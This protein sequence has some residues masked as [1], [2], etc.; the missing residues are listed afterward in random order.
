MRVIFFKK[1]YYFF[2]FLLI[3]IISIF[4]LE[5]LLRIYG[6]GDPIVYKTNLSYR[7]AP[8]ANQSVVRLKKSKISINESGLRSTNEWS[9][10]NN[11][12]VLFFGDSVTYGGS[13]IDD[14]EIFSELVCYNLNLA[15]KKYLCGNAGVNAYGVDNIN[16]RILYGEVQD[17]K[18][19]VVTLIEGDGYRSLQDVMAI[20]AFLDKPR[21]L[22]AIQEV[23]LHLTWKFNIFLRSDYSYNYTQQN[24][25]ETNSID[26]FQQSFKRLK[27]TLIN[28]LAKNKKILVVFHPSKESVLN[29]IETVEY[30]LMKNIFE[31][32]KS[33]I[34]FLDMFPIIK[35][36]YSS[37][38][39]YDTVHLDKKGHLLF[40]EQISKIINQYDNKY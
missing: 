2:I 6:L 20:P 29:G 26:I 5:T 28:E 3:F 15:K 30:K 24:K 21:L 16:N 8:K 39:Y 25:E 32:D 40:A 33:K 4:F 9:Q 7:Y 13:Y 11:H 31:E 37:N 38:I 22:P 17:S 10:N 18:W 12:K 35:S 23:L 36:F 1:A 27:D 14:K 19:I 34:I